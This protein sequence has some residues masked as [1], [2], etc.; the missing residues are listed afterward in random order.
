MFSI[1]IVDVAMGLYVIG[2][3]LALKTIVYVLRQLM[4]IRNVKV[5]YKAL[6][7]WNRRLE[8]AIEDGSWI[9]ADN[10]E[11]SEE[12]LTEI[13][14]ARKAAFQKAVEGRDFIRF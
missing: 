6:T 10:Y 12:V 4:A 9:D 8:W 2:A 14:E 5:A 1:S 13:V 11:F 3:L 7:R